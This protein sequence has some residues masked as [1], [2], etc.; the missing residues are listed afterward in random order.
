MEICVHCMKK[1]VEKFERCP[2]CG[3]KYIGSQPQI[4][5]IPQRSL[6]AGRYLVGVVLGAG[7]FGITYKAWDIQLDN[8]VAIKEYFPSSIVNRIP[9]QLQVTL[10]SEKNRA[11][12]AKGIEGFLEEAR[13]TAKFYAHPNIVDVYNFFEDNGTAYF[14]MEYLDGVSFREYLKL[15]GEKINADSAAE[16]ISEVL[17]ALS[18]VHSQGILHRDVSPDNIKINSKGTVVL[19]DFGAARFSSIETEKTRSVILKTGYAPPEQYERK[20]KQGPYTDIYAVGVCLYRAVTGKV[21]R[22][23]TNRVIDIRKGKDGLVPPRQIVPDIPEYF[24]RII[25]KAMA[26]QPEL[27]FQTSDEMRKAIWEQRLVDDVPTELRKRKI[28]RVFETVIAFCMVG[29]MGLGVWLFYGH[30]QD[31]VLLKETKLNIWMSCSD[32][33]QVLERKQRENTISEALEDFHKEYPQ[34]HLHISL[35]PE[36]EYDEKLEDSLGTDKQP[37]I[38]QCD[39]LKEDASIMVNLQDNFKTM[40]R[41]DYYT[42][43]LLN[44]KQLYRIPLGI[45]IPVIYVNTEKWDKNPSRRNRESDFFKGRSQ[46]FV[47]DISSYLDVQESFSG[48]Y[49]VP[50]DIIDIPMAWYTDYFCISIQSD[51]DQQAAARMLLRY[52]LGENAQDKLFLSDFHA[53]PVHKSMVKVAGEINTE[54]TDSIEKLEQSKITQLEKNKILDETYKNIMEDTDLI[55]SIDKQVD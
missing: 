5:H 51:E 37:D 7:G 54:L 21:P 31:A 11:E 48:N 45:N 9:G 24:E 15:H 4:N 17:A 41:D 39:H 1:V 28:V 25:L 53:L 6:L 36:S 20:S 49:L 23:S 33:L 18:A 19:F 50:E 8:V 35:I 2:H 42:E 46:M 14:V 3:A 16:I 13:N 22:E 32:D 55:E 43:K 47:G 29:M 10:A 40:S 52:L 38:F 26:I 30:K 44:A 34:V 27:R 12:F